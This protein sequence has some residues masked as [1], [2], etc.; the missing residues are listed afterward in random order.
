[1]SPLN[2][3]HTDRA[4]SR[5]C[6]R[7]RLEFLEDRLTP[8]SV[9]G[10]SPN[11][12][13]IAGGSLVTVTGSGFVGV[14]SVDFG[15]TP[16]TNLNVQ[17]ATTLT[18]DSPAGVGTADITVTTPSGTSP[19]TPADQF[20]YVAAPTVSSLSADTGPA[21]GGTLVTITGMNF[22]DVTAVDFGTTAAVD[23]TV[24]NP[25][26]ITALSPAGSGTVDVTVMTLGGKS[27]ASAFD[28]FTYAPTVSGISPTAGPT[29]GGTLVTITGT[30]FTGVTAV[31]FGANPATSFT[32]V[33]TT[34]I[35][36]FSPAG[37]GSVG[38]TVTTASGT[39]AISSGDVFAYAATPNV[40]GLSTTEGPQ[41]GGI[42]VTIT[43]TG[44]TGATSVNFGTSPATNLN[45]V[46]GTT[47]TATSPA[48]TGVVDV[49][50][51]TPGGTSPKTSADQFTY[52]A[53]PTV[54][55]LSATFGPAA[56]N[57]LVTI[58]GTGFTAATAVD[59]GTVAATNFTAISNSMITVESPPGTGTV[60]VTV[61]TPGGKSATS[62]SDEF[63][64]AP[65][66]TSISPAAGPLTGNTLV[67]LTGTGFIPGA[68]VTF[69]GVA[70]T[71]VTVVSAT[72]ITALS[73][74]GAGAVGVTVTTPSGTSASLAADVFT[75]FAAPTV[76]GID[77]IVGALGGGTSVTITGA[78][79]T[80]ASVV[81]F[82]TSPATTVTFVTNTTITATSP[83]GT[84]VVDVTVTTPGGTSP[85]TSAD[86]FTYVAAPTVSGL[87]ATF[88]PAAGNTLVTITGTGFTGATAVD[89]GTIAATNFTA[90]SNSMITV[91]SPPGT[92]TVDVTVTTPG[93]KS[94]TSPSDEFT[95]APTVSNISPSAGP[96]TGNTLVTLT[97]TGFVP[98]ST[99]TFG[100]VP[101][102]GVTVVSAGTIT[103]LS[104]AGTGAV[105]V[106]VTTPS[107]T[108]AIVAADLFNYEVAPVVSGISPAS[109][110]IGGG[111]L[112]TITGT[113]FT[114]ATAVDFGASPVTSVTVSSGSSI[115]AVSPAGTGTVNVTVITPGGT[116]ATS[117]ADQF[118]YA[119]APS[120]LFV[121]PKFGPAAG[122]TL[123]TISGTGFTGATAVDFGTVAATNLFAV[124]D[125]MIT[126]ESPPGTGTVDVTV[127]TPGGKSATSPSDEFAYAPTVSSISPSAG[128][129]TGNTLVTLTGTGFVPGATVAFGGVAATNVTVVSATTITALSPAGT[130][131]VGVT[132]TTPSGT[133]ATLPADVFTYAAVPVVSGISPAAGP[134][135]G[136]TTVTI[137]GTGFSG[138]TAV[139]FGTSPATSVTV[140]S[141]SSITAVSPAGTGTVNVTVVTPAGTSATSTA[142]QF[143]Y[144][145]APVVT[146]VSPSSGP[147]VGNTLVTINGSGFTGVTA[148]DFGATPATT[149]T[150]IGAAEIM[151]E[152]PPGTGTVDVTVVTGG[153]KSAT[154]TGDEFTYAPTILSISPMFGPSNGGTLVTITGT[155]F[156]VG[157][158]VAFAG[159]AATDVTV[160]SGTTIT[161]LS[162]A[163]SG[164]VGVAVT[165]PSGLVSTNSPTD[166]FTY[167]AV[168]TVSGVS[169]GSGPIGGGTLV[170]ISGTGFTG[171]TAVDFGTSPATDLAVLSPT[172]I[173]VESPAGTGTV[174]VTVTAL[175][176][177]SAKT[178]ADQF[179]YVAGP[180]ISGLAPTTGPS[181]GGTGVTIIGTGFTSGTAVYF[182][183]TPGTNLTIVSPTTITVESP[184]GTGSVAVTV[185][186]PSG[187]A[188]APAGDQFVYTALPTV[189]GI[190]ASSGPVS[191][192]TMVTIIGTNFA[193]ATA[194]DF[195]MAAA[196][197]IVSESADQIVVFS[198]VV[199]VAGPVD[200]TVT[201]PGGTSVTSPAD[202]F[203]Y[204][205]TVS[206]ITPNSGPPG[207]G[208]FV[209]I[210]GNGYSTSIPTSVLFGSVPA[211]E[212]NVLNGTTI[213]A[214]SPPGAGAVNV[215]VDTLGG[216]S[217]TSAADVF[218]YSAE[219]PKVLGVLRYGFHEQPTYLVIA[220]DSAIDAKSVENVANYQI[221]GLG[222]S[223]TRV[224]SASYNTAAHVVTLRMAKRLT[225]RQIYTLTINAM[226]STGLR[227]LAGVPLD[228]MGTGEPGTDYVTSITES[229]LAG[230]AGQRPKA[231]VVRA[232]ADEAL[233]RVKRHIATK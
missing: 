111:T 1:M 117:T 36:A 96:L 145:T 24:V 224:W 201:T 72:T 66:V 149:F 180:T 33:S 108:S 89:F 8:T 98:G 190:K 138:A 112:V 185:T 179:T 77:P 139:E 133:S 13:P 181:S 202:Q 115:T 81:D 118:S 26:T 173:M 153:G 225:L 169:P 160:L 191:G 123:V 88:G 194:I 15:A 213:T 182:G 78:N 147:A 28:V 29:A 120:V 198:P 187:S 130:G 10:V 69:G 186:T 211:T 2:S 100:G 146:S 126:V 76:S 219:G 231:I 52:V 31:D 41:G 103:A 87:S 58:T 174:D 134:V 151:V 93:G 68:T 82:G 116:S 54:S 141:G 91:E 167:A 46:S 114:G 207:G 30:G 164:V 39:S 18:V 67:T 25:T 148:V 197:S 208:T 163:G 125:S 136:G 107:G 184:A 172:S 226:G 175:G 132:V 44:F 192:G 45:V 37:T 131:A 34:S 47:I 84:G 204:G 170:S 20:T 196:T 210:V 205:V 94:A 11:A 40:A 60:D 209:T 73:P 188:G 119:T 59:F 53:A 222:G 22:T 16:G 221:A 42:S 106:T 217:A 229:D 86:Q 9:T 43:G 233:I 158:T 135:G 4:R 220:F 23:L 14:T 218:T 124:S 38:V 97:G 227:N 223:R 75:Y 232:R 5:R 195:G 140:S 56:G 161:A 199:A 19:T 214:E 102:T 70:A 17:S 162:P 57:T 177:T 63:T 200:V 3:R 165:T 6:F 74:A 110:P 183:M 168:P 171:A 143:S 166:M 122:N 150:A 12:G 121:I 61:T 50:V 35:A 92:G 95:Y 206:G 228:G 62:P 129:L 154:S 176:G 178:S 7:A 51:T 109:G 113:G 230:S 101:A 142:D 48:G 71:S 215:T 64:Y 193:G 49:T 189:T 144:A 127:T 216:Q 65:T 79:F 27:T 159:T 83:A 99:V 21:G 157:S 152:S 155:G 32:V 85:K 137:T 55:G 90:I 203:T 104:P 128:P 80:G 212:V 105:G 156:T